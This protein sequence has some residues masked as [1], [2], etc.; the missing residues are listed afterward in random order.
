MRCLINGGGKIVPKKL[1]KMTLT[2]E[3]TVAIEALGKVAAAWPES[4]ELVAEMDD[5]TLFLV[6]KHDEK[7]GLWREVAKIRGIGSADA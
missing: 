6:M 3:E 7:S 5:P 1:V 4:L 2:P